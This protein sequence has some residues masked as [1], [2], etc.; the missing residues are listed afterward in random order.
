MNFL[1]VIIFRRRTFKIIKNFCGSIVNW[2]TK[3][4]KSE[5]GFNDNE[6]S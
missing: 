3:I 5:E 2:V 6:L 1:N 4:S